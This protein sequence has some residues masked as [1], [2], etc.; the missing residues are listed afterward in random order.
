MTNIKEKIRQGW[1]HASLVIEV[2]GK[3]AEHIEQA[4]SL[5][6]DKLAKERDFELIEKKLHKAKPYEGAKTLFSA[7]VEI[8]FLVDKFSRLVEIIFDYMPSSVEII[9]P[10]DINF[11]LEYAN[12]F[13]NDLAMRLHQY[14]AMLKKLKLE[15]TI[16]AKRLDEMEKSGKKK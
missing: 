2:V 10:P 7:F 9:D 16:L 4:L 15:L 11:K 5:A 6:I 1:I 8:E 3:P 14:D 13:L 12:A